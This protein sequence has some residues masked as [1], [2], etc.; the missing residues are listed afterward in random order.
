[1]QFSNVVL[2]VPLAPMIEQSSPGRTA[3]LTLLRARGLRN[4]RLTS[5]TFWSCS[6]GDARQACRKILDD[7]VRLHLH[8]LAYDLADFMR[9]V[10]M[11][12]LW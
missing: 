9:M 11:A 8:A 2:P 12:P 4:E 5:S 1:M 7:A 3:K 6:S 10:W